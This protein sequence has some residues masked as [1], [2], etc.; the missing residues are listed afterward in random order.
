MADVK[1]HIVEGL[2]VSFGADLP[3]TCV[4]Y[5]MHR[6]GRRVYTAE[7]Y[8]CSC[9]IACAPVTW[10]CHRANGAWKCRDLPIFKLIHSET[11]D[12]MVWRQK[13]WL[14]DMLYCLV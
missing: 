6:F 14:L 8:M 10:Q 1:L 2:D 12:S 4:K 11:P 5:C 7:M 3:T 9:H 13:A